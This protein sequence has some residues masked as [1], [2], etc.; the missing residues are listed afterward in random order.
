MVP[1]VLARTKVDMHQIIDCVQAKEHCR[2]LLGIDDMVCIPTSAR[3]GEGV[4]IL[5]QTIVEQCQMQSQD[6]CAPEQDKTIL[7]FRPSRHGDPIAYHRF[8]V[9]EGLPVKSKYRTSS[10]RL[11]YAVRRLLCLT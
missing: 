3:T 11:R 4:A 7:S 5:F 2:S 10:S 9:E 8:D 1:V 6:F